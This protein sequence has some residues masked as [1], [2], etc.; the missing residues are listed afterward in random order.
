MPLICETLAQLHT[1]EDLTI[2]Q[3]ADL[4][5]KSPSQASRYTKS[6]VLDADQ[7]RT[8]FRRCHSVEAQRALL[9]YLAAESPWIYSLALSSSGTDA[10][11]DAGELP[12][13]CAQAME[14]LSS[15]LRAVAP[16]PSIYGSSTLSHD[17]A[18]V[19]ARTADEV[20]G[21]LLQIRQTAAAIADPKP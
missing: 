10:V 2:K 1:A 16:P 4:L 7:L 14:G 21:H 9:G 19:L 3:L 11:R 12:A 8:L 15:I 20:I 18:A 5:N 6:S 13:A 17:R